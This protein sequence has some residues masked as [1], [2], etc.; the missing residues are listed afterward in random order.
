MP[1][2][3]FE[4]VT[5]ETNH[6]GRH[7]NITNIRQVRARLT[8]RWPANSKGAAHRQAMRA[9]IEHLQGKKDAAAVREAFISA[10]KE[11]EIFVCEGTD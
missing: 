4:V 5:I 6:P 7:E 2:D 10:A 3:H 9:C 11:A 1:D 8:E